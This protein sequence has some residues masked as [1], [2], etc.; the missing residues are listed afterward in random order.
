MCAKLNVAALIL[1]DS[2]RKL[3]TP[4]SLEQ[5]KPARNNVGEA[6]LWFRLRRIGGKSY[7]SSIAVSQAETFE[8]QNHAAGLK[9][10]MATPRLASHEGQAQGE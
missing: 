10:R 4:L 5:L 8:E 7:K 9:R 1:S 3:L 6:M 2:D